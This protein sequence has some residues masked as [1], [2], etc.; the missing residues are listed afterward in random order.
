MLARQRAPDVPPPEDI[1]ALMRRVA[2]GLTAAEQPT[3]VLP[4]VATLAARFPKA[5][6][7][8][9][10]APRGEALPTLLGPFA[11]LPDGAWPGVTRISDLSIGHSHEDTR[12]LEHLARLCP[13]LLSLGLR[14]ADLAPD[15]LRTAR[16]SGHTSKLG[17]TCWASAL[18]CHSAVAAALQHMT[19]LQRVD[20]CLALRSS[21]S[22]DS[23]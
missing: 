23:D 21:Y 12:L 1:D 15:H 5:T 13:G 10:R 9:R 18:D 4:A 19:K 6:T 22:Y 16:S 17:L 7:L 14:L 8:L 3:E 2:L 20:I 11:A